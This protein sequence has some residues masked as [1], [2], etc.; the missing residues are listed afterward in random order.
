MDNLSLSVEEITDTKPIKCEPSMIWEAINKSDFRE[1]GKRLKAMSLADFYKTP[2]W[3]VISRAVMKRSRFRCE[4]CNEKGKLTIH[5]RT[6][7]SFGYE[8]MFPRDMIVA[9]ECCKGV[10]KNLRKRR[11]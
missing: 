11:K 9:C 5:R 10:V 4:I 3:W 6:W 2:Y 7:R 1:L 8:H